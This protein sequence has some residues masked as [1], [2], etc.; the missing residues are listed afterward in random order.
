MRECRVLLFDEPTR[1]IDIHAKSRIYA[2]LDEL[3]AQGKAVVIVSSETR[4]LME[5]CDHIAVLSNGRLTAM[6]GR[7]EWTL[8]KIMEASFRAYVKDNAA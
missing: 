5:V 2:L 8:E 7:D 4:E 3:A 1:G 6:F